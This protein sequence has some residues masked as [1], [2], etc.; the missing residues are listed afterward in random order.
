MTIDFGTTP[1]DFRAGIFEQKI[2]HRR[3]ALLEPAFAWADLDTLLHQIEPDERCLQLF[4]GGL[5]P[6]ERY[7]EFAQELGLRRRRLNKERFHDELRGGA[8]LVVNRL[9]SYSLAARRLCRE[10]ARFAG[11]PSIGNGYL[12]VGGTGTFGKHWDT[13]DV[14]ALQL[15]GRKRW[16]VFEPTFLHPLGDH[17]SQRLRHECPPDPVLDVVLETGDLLYIPRGWWHQA[18]PLDGASFHLSVGVYAP[19]VL[20]YVTW[21]C[22]R[23]LP[24]K[25][26]AR[27]G[28]PASASELG[29]LIDMV[30]AAMLDPAHLADFRRELAMAERP[31]PE[32]DLGL[33]LDH[34]LRALAGSD[35]L[36][37]NSTYA[38]DCER[39]EAAINGIVLRLD[40]L[41]QAILQ[42][43]SKL[44]STDVDTLCEKLS[45]ASPQA[46]HAAVLELAG[47]D[48]VTVL[49]S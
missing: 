6:Q 42:Q 5:I 49:R 37:L 2:H 31:V 48:V 15:M 25:V 23:Y 26:A 17:T 1:Q 30:K 28:L 16:Q 34:D 46:V 11:H 21:A 27:K 22:Q 3:A 41:S 35:R 44:P 40:R 8:T 18:I 36:R 38:L 45:P 13:H 4:N 20:D 33:F 7:T 24:L 9:E 39:G 43:L 14:F 19:S 29:P 32:F 12:S 10:V 47:H